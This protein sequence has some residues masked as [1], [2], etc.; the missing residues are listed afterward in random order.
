MNRVEKHLPWLNINLFTQPQI[1]TFL[2]LLI[3]ALSASGLVIVGILLR[4]STTFW[5]S[6]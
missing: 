3:I 4:F 6:E 1:S 2:L 5:I